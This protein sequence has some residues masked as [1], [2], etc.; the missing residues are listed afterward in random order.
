M[1]AAAYRDEP[2]R[3]SALRRYQIL[4]TARERDFDEVVQ[5]T[6]R[7]CGTPISVVSLVD[8]DR[9]WFKA[10]TGLGI[11]ETPIDTSICAHA[12]LEDSFLE[13]PDTQADPRFA[14]NPLCAGPSGL[15]F[16]AGAVLRSLDGLPIGTLCVL[17]HVP[18]VLDDTQ[19]EVLRVMADQVM[20]QINLRALIARSAILQGEM[21]HRVKNSLQTVSAFVALERTTA[22]GDESRE[23]L[24]RVAQQIDT[25]AVLHEQ[26]G[27][28]N[29]SGTVDL[30]EYLTRVTNLL[31]RATPN[32][33][34]TGE[35]ET[36]S[37]NARDAAVLGTIVNELV[38]N[39]V[40]HS[41][42]E[43]SGT[44]K[45]V[46]ASGVDGTFRLTCEDDGPGMIVPDSAQASRRE[47]L[48]LA[49]I[50]AS[51]RQLDGSVNSRLSPSGYRSE[52]SCRLASA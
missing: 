30:E 32:V 15:R 39:A 5:L 27:A 38:A 46:G 48:G 14:N 1:K 36:R 3:L 21:D 25:V 41:F 20:A 12:I 11:D 37:A 26:L 51:A 31:D 23:A 52:L 35:F 40:K 33:M 34:V 6:A 4:D 50:N 17:D 8:A 9:Q 10:E 18:R 49:I 24:G 47:G 22:E 19:R 45:L 28:S 7:L 44:I 16:Y 29:A 2:A 13:I 42:G 43:A